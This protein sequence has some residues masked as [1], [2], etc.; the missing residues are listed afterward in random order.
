VDATG[1][2]AATPCPAGT[3]NPNTGS[4]S[5][6]ACIPVPFGVTTTSLPNAT[7]GTKY[8]PTVTLQADGIGTSAPGY[9]ATL[10]WAKVSLPKGMKL[11]SKGV[12]SGTPSNTLA[13]G[14]SSIT[15]KVTETVTTLN[16]SKKVKTKNT[17]QATIPLTIN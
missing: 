7:P 9:T 3:Y 16:G 11:S 15:V 2:T 4:T 14:P 1:A 17:A 13:A 10:K 12:L 8:L 6:D 5:S